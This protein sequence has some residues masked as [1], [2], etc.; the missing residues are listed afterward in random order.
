MMRAWTNEG[1]FMRRA[2]VAASAALIVC[3]AGLARAQGMQARIHR[4][5]SDPDGIGTVDGAHAPAPGTV[6]AG[7]GLDLASRPMM[8]GGDHLL[9]DRLQ[10]RVALDPSLVFGLPSGF[11]VSARVPFTM[12]DHGWRDDGS[13][14][15]SA[16]LLSPSFAALIP[17]ARHPTT[18]ARVSARGEVI[19]PAGKQGDYRGE[20]GFAGRLELVF[21]GPI[22]PMHAVLS[23]GGYLAPDRT[24]D[25]AGFGHAVLVGAG[26]RIPDKSTVSLIGSLSSRFE[27]E[28]TKTATALGAGGIDLRFGSTCVRAMIGSGAGDTPGTPEFW[29][30]FSL[31]QGIELFPGYEYFKPARR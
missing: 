12:Y 2:S 1:P 23:G 7:A 21:G 14:I 10:Y 15:S 3:S 22:G 5:T 9:R 25:T 27:I 6:V 31:L 19:L 30:G 20:G 16:G 18:N 24:L 8:L 28:G 26:I 29:M 4:M 11:A 13:S 17:I